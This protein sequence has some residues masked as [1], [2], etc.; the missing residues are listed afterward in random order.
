MGILGCGDVTEI[1]VAQHSKTEGFKIEAVM[2]RDGDKAADYAKRHGISK[3]YTDADDL[4]NDP[5]VDAIYIATPPDT[6]KYYGLK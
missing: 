4:I 2:R 5:E 3:Y 1:K 6:H